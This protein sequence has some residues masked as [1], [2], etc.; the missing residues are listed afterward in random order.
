MKKTEYT[1]QGMRDLLEEMSGMYDVAR[2]VDPIECRILDCG[3]DG[4]LS[5]ADRCYSIWDSEQKCTNCSSATACQTCCHQQKNEHFGDNVFHIQ[6]NPVTLKLP[7]GGVYD[8]VVELVSVEKENTENVAGTNDRRAENELGRA[9]MYKALHDPLTRVLNSGAFYEHVRQEVLSDPDKDHYMIVANIREFR[10]VNALF[11]VLKGNEILV[12]TAGRLRGI[13]DRA[14]GLC[15]RLSGDQFGMFIPAEKYD[16]KVLIDSVETLA[17]AFSSGLY[18]FCIQFGA[19]EVSDSSIPVSVMCDRANAA[20]HTKHNDLISG[21]AYFDDFMMKE[22][23]FRQEVISGFEDALENGEFQMYLQ[24]LAEKDGHVFAAEALVRWVRPDG[25]LIMPGDFIETLEQAGLIHELD[26]YMWEQAVRQ[27]AEWRGTNKASVSISVNVSAKDFYSID[28]YKTITSLVEQY[29]VDAGLL[30]LE[31]TETAMLE[32]LKK[33]DSVIT[34]LQEYGFIVEIDDFGKG[35]SSISLLKEIA[36]D[37]LKIDMS[38]I[39][40][41]ETKD[42]SLKILSS[43]I[44][45]AHSLG[46]DVITEGVETEEQLELLSKIG[47]SHFQGYYFYKPLPYKEFGRISG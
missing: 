22:S 37:V 38:L 17:G 31:I 20:L 34:A 6:S 4:T 24:P 44:Q 2:V 18:T 12:R 30:R 23:L 21:V 41:I 40:E 3:S 16:E 26:A 5:M 7:D 27:L 46:M 25:R 47:C 39:R 42:R 36:A 28:I 29:G 13:T 35:Y 9:S 19:Y 11:G 8:A 10:L 1:V 14:G 15:G 32:D 45:M 43:V 33:T